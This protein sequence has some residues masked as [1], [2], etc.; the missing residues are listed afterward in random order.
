MPSYKRLSDVHDF[1]ATYNGLLHDLPV[2][3]GEHKTITSLRSMINLLKGCATQAL[4][5]VSM[6]E[7]DKFVVA[8]EEKFGKL[9][10]R[11]QQIVAVCTPEQEEVLHETL[12]TAEEFVDYLKTDYKKEHAMK[13]NSHKLSSRRRSHNSRRSRV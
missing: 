6:D 12:K 2:L 5:P 4:S 3:P 11:Q 1:I 7:I 10:L 8:V 9:N 13:I